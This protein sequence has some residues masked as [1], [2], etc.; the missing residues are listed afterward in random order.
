MA[1]GGPPPG[2]EVSFGL[3]EQSNGA[4]RGQA[5][6]RVD[7]QTAPKLRRPSFSPLHCAQELEKVEKGWTSAAAS[8][9]DGETQVAAVPPPPPR[10]GQ[11]APPL[12]RSLT[13]STSLKRAESML[14]KA[15][16]G[17]VFS[18]TAHIVTAGERQQA[19]ATAG[20]CSC[21]GTAAVR[22]S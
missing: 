6:G 3:Q 9:S 4:R 20:A 13:R 8:S 18:A 12:R 5:Y 15:R 10:R 16:Q 1:G 11:L 7:L 2:G 17:T 19:H 14:P 21:P 22:P